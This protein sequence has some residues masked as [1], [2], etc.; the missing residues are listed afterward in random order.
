LESTLVISVPITSRKTVTFTIPQTDLV[1]NVLSNIGK[2]LK[3]VALKS[4]INVKLGAKTVVTVLLVT[5]D[6]H[7]G[8]VL[9]LLPIKENNAN[10]HK[11][12]NHQS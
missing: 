2:T 11:A 1:V 9:A 6:I 4:T 7:L 3:L 5:Q 10:S 12:T 8:L